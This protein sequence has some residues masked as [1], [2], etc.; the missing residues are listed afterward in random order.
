M[1][2]PEEECAAMADAMLDVE[3]V[4][5]IQRLDG[6]TR[7]PLQKAVEA[8]ARKRGLAPAGNNDDPSL[9]LTA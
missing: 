9:D 2:N 5:I 7:T 1:R 8:E 3:I 4:R 6:K